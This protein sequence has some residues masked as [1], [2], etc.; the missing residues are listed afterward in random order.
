MTL[1]EAQHAIEELKAQGETE[2]TMLATF[3][4][5]FIDDELTVEQLGDLCE[6]IGYELTD[7]FRNMSPEDQKTKGW[8][9]TEEEDLSKE[10]IEDA[11]E[12]DNEDKKDYDGDS[13]PDAKNTDNKNSKTEPEESDDEK[14]KKL[15][16]F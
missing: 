4:S 9:E 14:A 1:K 3:Y 16:G 7:E 11:K 5:M 13:N 10:E 2:E 12:W 15:F 6:L 8:E